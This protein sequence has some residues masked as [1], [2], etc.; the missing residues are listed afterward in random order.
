[1]MTPA[2]RNTPATMKA[3]SL[4]LFESARFLDFPVVAGVSDQDG[5]GSSESGGGQRFSEGSDCM[6]GV[7]L[8]QLGCGLLFE[9]EV[10]A[11]GPV[12]EVGERRVVLE[13]ED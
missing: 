13:L 4:V 8:L 7:V 5:N 10:D 1:M 11:C 9:L 2:R 3:R 12:G 6:A